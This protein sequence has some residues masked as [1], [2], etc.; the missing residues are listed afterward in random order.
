MD[1]PLDRFKWFTVDQAPALAIE[2]TADDTTLY[3][4]KLPLD[5]ETTETCMILHSTGSTADPKP[6]RLT[7]K[8]VGNM[9]TLDGFAPDPAAYPAL[10]LTA[11]SH[12]YALSVVHMALA[13]GNSVFISPT[14]TYTFDNLR[15]A[16]KACGGKAKTMAAVPMHLQIISALP[17]GLGLLSG[18]E[19]IRTGGGPLAPG[20]AGILANAGVYV[21]NVVSTTELAV[22]LWHQR[23]SGIGRVDGDGGAGGK[24][25]GTGGDDGDGE[26]EDAETET[27]KGGGK[28]EADAEGGGGVD[29][30]AESWEW[31]NVPFGMEKYVKF[32]QYDPET[33]SSEFI[34]LPGHPRLYVSN[35]TDGSYAT[36]DL[37]I[38]HP[39]IQGKWKYDKRKDDVSNVFYLDSLFFYTGNN[40]TYV[41]SILG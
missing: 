20:V 9:A 14:M 15:A 35:R 3:R 25:G 8:V 7:N 24:A 17:D 2:E 13:T 37:F 36:N 1:L 34:A 32:E 21:Q 22:M 40:Y 18:F 4:S 5:Q 6:V 41:R 38:P 39:S 19:R 31:L 23:G 27:G 11:I 28:R 30:E 33:G 29:S 16:I 26:N 10:T 12:A